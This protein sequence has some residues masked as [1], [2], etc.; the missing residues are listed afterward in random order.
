MDEFSQK[1][2]Q[3]NV[4]EVE[5][6]INGIWSASQLA[7]KQAKKAK[8]NASKKS[9]PASTSSIQQQVSDPIFLTAINRETS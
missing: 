8:E 9:L 2:R 1:S 7:S 6:D 5:D 3:E 4:E